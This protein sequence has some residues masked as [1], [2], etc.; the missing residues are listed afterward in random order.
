[1]ARS[2][3]TN[4][5]IRWNF[6]KQLDSNDDVVDPASETPVTTSTASSVAYSATSVTFLAANTSR[7]G[8]VA[9]NTADKDAYVRESATAATA[10]NGGFTYLVRAGDRLVLDRLVYKGGMTVI[11][12]AGGSGG[13][14]ISER[15]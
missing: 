15:V 9:E 6:V 11:W 5:V 2:D 10:S 13:F 12:A 4:G 7:L 8:V 14:N 1:M 3:D